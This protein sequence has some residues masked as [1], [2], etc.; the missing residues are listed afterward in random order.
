MIHSALL[1][2]LC[3]CDRHLARGGGGQEGGGGRRGGAGGG[4]GTASLK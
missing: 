2:M 4:G 1:C 3:V